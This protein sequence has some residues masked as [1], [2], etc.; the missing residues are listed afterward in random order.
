MSNNITVRQALKA[1]L[2]IS[3]EL[4]DVL[5]AKRGLDGDTLLY[6]LYESGESCKYKLALA[7]GIY[8]SIRYLGNESRTERMGNFSVT[9]STQGATKDLLV[10]KREYADRLYEEC[11]ETPPTAS[12]GIYDAT[13]LWKKERR[14]GCCW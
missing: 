3:D 12:E 8:N 11:G 2:G 5:L 9:T 13:H 4:I 14:C 6:E 1:E 7:D 10:A